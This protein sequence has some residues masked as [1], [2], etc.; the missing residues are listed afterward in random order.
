MKLSLGLLPLLIIV[1]ANHAWAKG[2]PAACYRVRFAGIAGL[3]Q[4]SAL[5]HI[6]S[7]GQ[8][9]YLLRGS[10]GKYLKVAEELSLSAIP[11]PGS[12]FFADASSFPRLE[13]KSRDGRWLTLNQG[14]FALSTK[15]PFPSQYI[16]SPGRGCFD[17][18]GDIGTNAR[19]ALTLR[20][21]ADL[22]SHPFANDG[23]GGKLFHGKAFDP[24]GA[25]AALNSCEASHGPAGLG[26]I[27]GN[28]IDGEFSHSNSGFPSFSGWPAWDDSNHQQMYY[29]WIERAYRGGLRLLVAHAVN[30]EA[31]C[32][33]GRQAD[34]HACDDMAAVD[35]Q[36]Q[37]AHD[38]EAY[39]D[40]QHGGPGKGWLRIV[41]HAGEARRVI[42]SGKLAMVL[43][44]EVDS[45]FGCKVG[46]CTPESVLASLDA[47]RARGVRQIFPIHVTDNAFGGAALYTPIVF[48][49]ANRLQNGSYFKVEDCSAKGF[50]YQE[51][52]FANAPWTQ[53]VIQTQKLLP[54]YPP[55]AAHCNAQG[56]TELG[57]TL[58]LGMMQRG[59]LIDIDHMS[60]KTLDAVLA[61]AEG[62][63][64]PLIS[65][66]T[67][68]VETSAVGQKRSEAQKTDE[69]LR[70]VIRL[71]GIIAPILHQGK[72]KS[73]IL[74][75]G[76]VPNDCD[77]SSKTWAQTY[78]YALSVFRD[79]GVEPSL[80][81]GSDFNG[82]IHR[83]APRFGDD[84][85]A[86]NRDQGAL[87]ENPVHYPFR[88]PWVA[89]DFDRIRV[90]ERTFDINSDGF[91]HVGLLPDFIEELSAIGI[92]AED[93][94]PLFESAEA[95]IRVWEKAEDAA[96]R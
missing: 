55:Y 53:T 86:G 13:M 63:S 42:R 43:G 34:D 1:A 83:P 74:D 39:I 41:T 54:S 65:G 87:Q 48:N 2:F 64:Y 94:D 95:Y 82:I 76:P 92:S 8:G 6:Q 12:E 40:A 4:P 25:S 47:Y 36:I 88:S 58:I 77:R 17:P 26:D 9:T 96:R 80:A 31:L 60:A 72:A 19:P 62:Q 33:F 73:E 24:Y 81:L 23:F 46:H 16:V 32:R 66:H 35:R 79:E 89:A 71:G 49:I 18:E 20:G 29:R 7:S 91:A 38:L 68:F 22:H 15:D 37:A 78:D 69:Q 52:S 30:S 67:G 61:I 27:I 11:E 28:G 51:R 70:R 75:S 3:F 85:C 84:A 14:R 50:T 57:R 10:D 59:M 93:L 5:L 21:I 56:L 90:G 44:I 45:L